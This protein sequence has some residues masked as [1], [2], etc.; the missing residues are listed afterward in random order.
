MALKKHKKLCSYCK[1]TGSWLDCLHQVVNFNKI[2][3]AIIV[4]SNSYV[5]TK[6]NNIELF[7]CAVT[8]VSITASFL[9]YPIRFQKYKILA[10]AFISIEMSNLL[11]KK[12]KKN[13]GLLNE[14]KRCKYMRWTEAGHHH[15]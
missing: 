8:G 1:I 7:L 11:K 2:K 9:K 10:S 15:F 6:N 5:G 12:Q 14:Q 3:N 4:P 13:P